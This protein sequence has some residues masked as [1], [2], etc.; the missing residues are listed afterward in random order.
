MGG[1][2]DGLGFPPPDPRPPKVAKP[3]GSGPRDLPPVPAQREPT[4]FPGKSGLPSF[5]CQSR[6]LASP[7]E[8]LSFSAVSFQQSAISQPQCRKPELSLRLLVRLI[9]EC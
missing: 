4:R 8:G 1:E 6:A 3:P 7:G 9:A 2:R 5:P